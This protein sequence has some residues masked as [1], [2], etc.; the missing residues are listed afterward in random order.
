MFSLQRLLGQSKEFFGLLEHSAGLSHEA[1]MALDQ[2]VSPP[3][4]PPDLGRIV[5]A[6]RKDKELIL[7]LEEML[8][9]VFITPLEREDLEEVAQG[10]YK[11]PKMVEKFAERYEISWE[12][13]QEVDFTL[14]VR[15][16]VR[17]TDLVVEMVR[18]LG[19]G[20]SHAEI[21]S[22][23]ARLS[24]VEADTS[25]ILLTAARSLYLP[26]TPPLRAII[27]KELFDILASGIDHCRSVG[28][29][30]AL[31]TLKNS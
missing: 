26:G 16:L 5:A 10:L 28:R 30:L 17:A 3:V 24:Q 1:A 11:L 25:H 7:K 8:T 23:E 18:C 15:M 2:M 19:N 22:L 20:G 6:R 21:K 27:A 4:G 29:T 13:V 12:K 9:C 31:V 14:G